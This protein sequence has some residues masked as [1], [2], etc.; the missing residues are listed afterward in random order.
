VL[1][2]VWHRPALGVDI[3]YAVDVSATSKYVSVPD[4]R[5]GLALVHDRLWWLGPSTIP[6][7]AETQVGVVIG[8]RID[9]T[10]GHAL[11]GRSLSGW[12]D[13]RVPLDT[14]TSRLLS[15]PEVQ[16]RMFDL[17]E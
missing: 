2:T 1:P 4:A 15:R 8:V 14:L 6:W 5:C 12:R 13:Q 17:D 16:G 10:Y 7:S 3:A 11:A 9:R